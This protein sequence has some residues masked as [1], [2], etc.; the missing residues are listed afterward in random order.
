MLCG[1]GGGTSGG[2]ATPASGIVG[3]RC[4][5]SEMSPL[6][7]LTRLLISYYSV[8]NEGLHKQSVLLP[9]LCP[10]SGRRPPLPCPRQP[11]SVPR[12]RR[13][14]C[15]RLSPGLRDLSTGPSLRCS[16][17]V[18]QNTHCCTVL[19]QEAAPSTSALRFLQPD[20]HRQ[21]G[22]IR[23]RWHVLEGESCFK[24]VF[25]LGSSPLYECSAVTKINT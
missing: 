22:R 20:H 9:A 3:S 8:S 13:C 24:S 25:S 12:W 15:W 19:C 11:T 10:R 14:P 2:F 6:K 21:A 1:S 4:S 7:V 17:S 23:G 5:C 16:R 18:L